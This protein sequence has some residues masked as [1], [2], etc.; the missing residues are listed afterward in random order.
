LAAFAVVLVLFLKPMPSARE[1]IKKMA[2]V[3]TSTPEN[4]KT[5][6]VYAV[7]WMDKF[8]ID[9]IYEN[10]I[11][12]EKGLMQYLDEYVALHP[13]IKFEI[14]TIPYLEYEN[15]LK[16]LDDV[17]AVP[18]I[19]QIYSLWGVSYV[20]DNMIDNPP[21]DI[22]LDVEKN[23]VSKAGATIDGD[24]WGIPG[25]IN[26]YSLIYNKKMFKDAGIVDKNGEALAPKTWND[27]VMAAKKL[28]KKDDKG[29]ITRY[30]FAFTKGM[31][32]AV[33]DPFLSLL[34]S[35]G[36]SYLSADN[37][38]ALFNSPA[39]VEVLNSIC[40]LFK[41]GATDVNSNVWD[42]SDGKVAMAFVA[43]WTEG[44]FKEAMGDRFEKEVA[45]APIPYFKNPAS[46]QYD[47]FLGVMN[48]SKN[49]QASWDFLR[50]FTTDI[51]PDRGT[52]RYGDLLAR[53]I[54]AIPNRKVDLENNKDMLENNFFKTPFI[55]QLLISTP[56]PN[57][58]HA[59]EIR[60]IMLGEIEAAFAG[61][62]AKRALDDAAVKINN[63]LKQ[64]K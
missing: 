54:K 37:S 21:K 44:V 27:L 34:M 35:N 15:K 58:L 12:K 3:A 30:G 46:L 59:A 51:Q 31:D 42:F 60:E 25:E 43:P 63:I 19:F 26:D 38:Q 49:K 28:A 7:H 18:D 47:W 5:K 23:Y 45:V 36:G 55:S 52:T 40:G 48:K 32:W 1:E 10:G 24:I 9:G 11:L 8:Q 56:Q 4:Q 14:M 61:K 2:N 17:D 29:N 20:E 62:D 13:N 53:T 22:K 57:I 39:G 33:V 64:N 16:L 50:W 41:N 6:I